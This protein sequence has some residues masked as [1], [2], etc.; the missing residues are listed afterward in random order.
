MLGAG[1]VIVSGLLAVTP[2]LVFLHGVGPAADE[3][4]AYMIWRIMRS[5]KRSSAM[6]SLN[7]SSRVAWSIS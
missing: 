1:H 7:S 6:S 3:F 5:P 4:P 2:V